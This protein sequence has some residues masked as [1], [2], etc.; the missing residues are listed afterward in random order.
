MGNSFLTVR[1][2]NHKYIVVRKDYS[3]ILSPNRK[4]KEALKTVFAA[5]PP[6]HK[7]EFLQKTAPIPAKLSLFSFLLVQLRYIRKRVWILAALIFGFL[8]SVSFILSADRIWAL[9]AFTPL[10]ALLTVAETGRSEIYEMA[11]LEMATRFS[12]RSVLLARLCIL[13]LNNLFLLGLL[14]PVSLAGSHIPS[15]RA[16][17]CIATPFLLTSFACLCIVRRRRERESIYLCVGVTACISFFTFG[18]RLFAPRF[19]SETPFIYWLFAATLL[20]I[21]TFYQYHNLIRQEELTWNFS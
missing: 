10:L 19:L 7:K 12:L 8:F 1:N 4:T 3:M 13:G 18:L 21:G 6:L 9:S 11:E 2:G 15:L 16:V 20:G 17:L 5:P 14:F